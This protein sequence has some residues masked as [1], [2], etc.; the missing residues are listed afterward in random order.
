M[1]GVVNK[2]LLMTVDGQA[3]ARRLIARWAQP[4]SNQHMEWNVQGIVA[5]LALT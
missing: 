3:G 1:Q 5:A 4:V 2:Q